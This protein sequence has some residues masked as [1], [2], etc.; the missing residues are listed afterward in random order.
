VQTVY[1]P[2]ASGFT[3]NI[4]RFLFTPSPTGGTLV[5]NGI[6]NGVGSRKGTTIESVAL[7]TGPFND[8]ALYL[9]YSD[10]GFT[11]K[12]TTP[13]VAPAS[14]VQIA[15]LFN[16]IGGISQAFNG[17]DLYISELGP[18]PIAGQFIKKG[19]VTN[20]LKAS[21]SMSQGSASPVKRAIARLQT[22][23]IIV[24]NPGGFA[25]GPTTFRPAC[26]PPPG[27]KLSST[28]PADPATTP[29]FYIGT[30]GMPADG[31]FSPGV[32]NGLAELPEVDQFDFICNV[33]VTYVTQGVLDPLLS[34]PVDLGSVT[35]IAFSGTD[36]TA[37]MAVGDDPSVIVAT[38]TRQRGIIRKNGPPGTGSQGQGHV[39]LVF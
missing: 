6:L 10:S 35:S 11:E 9:L 26:L 18:P 21:P 31:V 24:E 19:Q 36:A 7:P 38:Q 28:V 3:S 27:V 5:L 17:N 16:G 15:R 12:I 37:V 4:Y 34:T 2:D 25:V 32:S 20:L 13:D 39:Y 33:Q 8:G 1:V 23:Q 14:P 30:L 22:P 29:A